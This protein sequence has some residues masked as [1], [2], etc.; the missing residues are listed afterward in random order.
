MASFPRRDLDTSIFWK[1]IYYMQFLSYGNMWFH[2]VTKGLCIHWVASS[3]SKHRDQTICSRLVVPYKRWK[4]IKNFKK[5]HAK[6][7][8]QLL[9][10][11]GC[12]QGV[13]EENL[14][15][16]IGGCLWEVVTNKRWLCIILYRGSTVYCVL[17]FGSF[18]NT[19]PWPCC[20][21]PFTNKL[22]T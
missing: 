7:L 11:G 1:I 2:F 17:H 19:N 5:C 16:W 13:P 4:T 15:L 18:N 21:K 10:R 12:L 6:K 8:S 3:Y 22:N 14:A 9:T 20:L